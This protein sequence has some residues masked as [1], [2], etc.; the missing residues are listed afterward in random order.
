[1]TFPDVLKAFLEVGML[2]L[3][4]IMMCVIFYENHK[5]S[6]QTDDEKNK[7]L[8]DNFKSLNNKMDNMV[9]SITNQNNRF[10]EIQEKTMCL[11]DSLKKNLQ[12]IDESLKQEDHGF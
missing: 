8:V 12:H 5:R 9:S 3:C 10:V 2:G 11:S 1:M 7:L 6:H 4:A